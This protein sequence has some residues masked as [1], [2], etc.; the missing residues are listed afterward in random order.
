M[1]AVSVNNRNVDILDAGGSPSALWR[2]LH[3]LMTWKLSRTRRT[4][5]G[6]VRDKG[7]KQGAIRN[8]GRK[9]DFEPKILEQ[10]FVQIF[11]AKVHHRIENKFPNES[12]KQ[13]RI[14]INILICNE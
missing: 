6:K 7:A 3:A 9:G 4:N 12:E 1:A 5:G 14:N 8:K 2:R 11:P 13:K 10:D